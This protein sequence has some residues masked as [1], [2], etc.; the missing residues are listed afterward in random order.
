[1]VFL[2]PSA[3]TFKNLFYMGDMEELE[4]VVHFLMTSEISSFSP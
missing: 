3:K 2:T 4:K 1:V